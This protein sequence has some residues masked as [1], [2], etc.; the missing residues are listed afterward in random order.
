MERHY[1]N[2]LTNTKGEYVLQGVN[3]E[4]EPAY[5]DFFVRNDYQDMTIKLYQIQFAMD[6]YLTIQAPIKVYYRFM[7]NPK[8]ELFNISSMITLLTFFD[9]PIHL[10]LRTRDYLVMGTDLRFPITLGY[11]EQIGVSVKG[12]VGNGQTVILCKG[13]VG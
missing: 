3:E 12:L 1:L 10:A 8:I 11:G 4:G 9:K 5:Q 13:S 7:D 6:S 2:R